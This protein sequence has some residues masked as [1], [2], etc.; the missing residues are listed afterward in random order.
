[1]K[2]EVLTHKSGKFIFSNVFSKNKITP[3]LLE[4]N[5]RYKTLGGLPILPALATKLNEDLIL[6]SIFGT[7]AIEG[8][9]LTEEEVE[10]I[11]TETDKDLKENASIEIKNLKNAYGLLQNIKFESEN[12]IL[13]EK[14]I[15]EIHSIITD[16]I[17]HPYDIPGQYRNNRVKVG[18]LN[19]GGVYTPPK[20]IDDIKNL[21]S[22]FIDWINS[23]EIVKLGPIVRASLAHYYLGLIHP[24]GDGNGRTARM[25]EAFI[26]RASNY[27]FVTY[28]LSN[29]YYLNKDDYFI[30]FSEAYKNPSKDTT[31]FLNFVLKGFKSALQELEE[32]ITF[33]IRKFALKDYFNL[34]RDTKQ[35]TRRQ[36]DL[37][38]YLLSTAQTNVFFSINDLY[39]SSPYDIL[40]RE[41]STQTAN[42]DI[43]K[44]YSMNILGFNSNKKTYF[45]NLRLLDT[46]SIS[47]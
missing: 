44:L 46:L 3:L 35:I 20:C 8:N 28:M 37:L 33:Y 16:N 15:K 2:K 42:R 23:S 19:H 25:V 21:M 6:R 32:K 30:A 40:Y 24:F 31:P 11:V 10:K 36:H 12:F 39:T 26:L 43:K 17:S 7:A 4:L 1:M 38:N 13:E 18:D 27:K 34:L 14:V 47:I 41:V 22:I 29:Y 5:I 45:L 9:P